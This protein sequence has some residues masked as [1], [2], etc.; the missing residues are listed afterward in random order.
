MDFC[1]MVGAKPYVAAN[2]TTLR[3]LDIRDW[4]E[5]CN[6]PENST[7]YARERAANGHP[8]PFGVEYWG[9][10]NENWGDG[11]HMTPEKYMQ[12]FIRYRSIFRSINKPENK[13]IMCGANGHDIAWTRRTLQEWRTQFPEGAPAWGVGIHYYC[14]TAG[15]PQDFTEEQWYELLQKASFMRRIIDDHRAAMDEFDPDREI[16]MVIDEWGCWHRDGSGPSKGCNLFEQQSSMRDAVVAAL[17]LNLF[18]NRCHVV[19]MANIAQL[20]NNLHSLYLAGGEHFVETPN[21]HVFDMFQHHQGA[22]QVESILHCP[23]RQNEK[24]DTL[25]M[26]SASASEKDGMI[27]LTLANLHMTESQTL[28]L[29]AI[30]GKLGTAAEMTVL[31]HDDVHACNTF[32]DPFAVVPATETVVLGETIEV[33]A[34]SV[35][36]LRIPKA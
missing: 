18:N 12:E 8:A 9:I 21:Y 31:R 35:V 33:P 28:K 19:R 1:G 13:W 4:I 25:E 22:Q 17:T 29:S 11:G 27:T 5:Y 32:V 23:V 34:A 16:G 10:G 15:N 7:T 26:L 3:P 2:M 24:G 36:L 30:G 6:F 14:G 20:C